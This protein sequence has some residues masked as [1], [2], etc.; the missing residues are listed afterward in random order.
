MK[1]F[2]DL[3]SKNN[4]VYLIAEI[5]VNYYD[6]AT[7]KNIEIMDAAKLMIL[8]AK[9]CGC[10]A[11]KFQSYK[12]N[13]IASKN[14]PA[15]WDMNEEK[16]DSQYKLFK[17]YDRFGESEYKELADYCE[18]IGIDFL[19]TPFDEDAANFLDPM[20]PFFKVSSSDITNHPFLELIAS[21]NK[22][23]LLSTGA[24]NIDEIRDALQAIK[25][26]N[27]E[28]H[29]SIMHCVLSYP[30]KNTDANLKNILTLA[31]SF[32][33]IEIGYSDHT[34]PDNKMLILS[35]AYFLGAKIIE[36]HF[37]LDKKLEGNDHYHSM[38][39]SDA[40]VFLS[41]LDLLKDI[42]TD[43]KV[44][45]LEC[46]IKSRKMARR[47]IVLTKDVKAGAKVKR[48]DLTFKRPGTGISPSKLS[49]VLER[50]YLVDIKE[51]TILTAKDF[52]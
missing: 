20:V 18:T 46:E 51:D 24:S 4:G 25:K 23:V 32:S 14:S 5:G 33:N 10:S 42:S 38:D 15:Y 47:S 7:S 22:P 48:E 17:K 36:K 44:H 27:K 2:S 37:T 6:I 31:D 52:K 45:P 13:K 30:T 29:I 43:A 49:E 11:A 19:S 40:K 16:S 21:K 50:E 28:A 9:N 1:F 39:T 3:I 35:C 41:E 8:E 12:A 34:K 26:V